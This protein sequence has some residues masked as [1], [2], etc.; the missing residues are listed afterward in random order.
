MKILFKAEESAKAFDSIL[1]HEIVSFLFNDEL[2]LIICYLLTVSE[3]SVTALKE[4]HYVS[5]SAGLRGHWH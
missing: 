1:A 2:R 4:T 5:D 3:I